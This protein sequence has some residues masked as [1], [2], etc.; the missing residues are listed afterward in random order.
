MKGLFYHSAVQSK[1]YYIVALCLFVAFLTATIV[2]FSNFSSSAEAMAVGM[3]IPTLSLG[4]I[5]LILLEASSKRTEKMLQCGFLKYIMTSGVS[6]T[7]YVLAEILENL[8]YVAVSSLLGIII[9]QTA[10]GIAPEY[11]LLGGDNL[12]FIPLLCFFYG[13]FTFI[14]NTLMLFTKS[15]EISGLIMGCVLGFGVGVFIYNKMEN[16]NI[17]I[18]FDNT[19][20]LIV[21]GVCLALYAVSAVIMKLRLERYSG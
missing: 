2:I 14:L 4:I 18:V 20:I 16:G 6:R 12:K 13:T 3:L 9:M 19:L 8:F 17:E 5:P 11:T 15:S 7:K 10:A 1:T 21:A